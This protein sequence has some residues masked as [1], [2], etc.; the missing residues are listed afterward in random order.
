MM[1][2]KKHIEIKHKGGINPCE[3]CKYVA[4]TETNLKKH[5]KRKHEGV[6]YC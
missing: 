6:R 5:I 3:K 2:L 1:D 4:T